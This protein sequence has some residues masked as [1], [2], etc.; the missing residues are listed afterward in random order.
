MSPTPHQLSIAYGRIKAL[1]TSG[2]KPI[3]SLR[4][5]LVP[6]IVGIVTL[7]LSRLWRLSHYS[8]NGDE[9]FSIRAARQ[10][11][12]EMMQT[13]AID[14][15]HPPLFYAILKIWMAIEAQS[16]F[17]LR[18]LPALLGIVSVVPLIMICRELQ[19]RDPETATVVFLFSVNSFLIAYA[20]ELRMYSLLLFCSLVS[21]WLFIRY[22]DSVN[23]QRKTL[24]PLFLVNLA[25][26]YSHYFGWLVVGVESLIVLI[27]NYRR[28]TLFAIMDV[29]LVI[30]YLPWIFA[31][32]QANNE[33]P[34][35]PHIDWVNSPSIRNLVW[36]Y[37]QLNGPF[38]FSRSTT[39][40]ILLFGIPVL[41][42]AYSLIRKRDN[43]ELRRLLWLY[44]LAFLPPVMALGI[45]WSWRSVWSE[46]YLII[47][48][49]PYL[50]L[51]TIGA[52]RLPSKLAASVVLAAILA[53]STVSGFRFMETGER[54]LQWNWLASEMLNRESRGTA[55]VIVFTF[56]PFVATALEFHLEAQPQTFKVE[57][58]DFS[59][60]EGQHFWVAFRNTTWKE[61]RQPQ[62][63]LS[64]SGYHI[65]ESIT[66]VTKHQRVTVFP[67][68]K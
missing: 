68:D 13:I 30:C 32:F 63:L 45:S 14:L 43:T 1:V 35:S 52:Y 66:I 62:D 51:V 36:F 24:I 42:T 22:I 20:Q 59:S 37:A 39:L 40:G 67:V 4:V 33:H 29:S 47:C 46:R 65:G 2:M 23:K 44:L 12:S 18:L 57:L 50:I 11:W 25:L 10:N 49:A 38:E 7:V 17:W 5:G 31:V 56:E 64:D 15:V 6:L 26:V 61:S 53:W 9:I 41:I 58:N 27:W 16:V 55:P 48:A 28:R 60:I 21:I 34:L 54:K 8:L 19:L 3:G